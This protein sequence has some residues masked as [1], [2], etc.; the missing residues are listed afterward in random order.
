MRREGYELAVSR[1]E[2]IIKEI[3]GVSCEPYENVVIDIEEQH[4]GD[5][6]QMLAEAKGDMKNMTPD[7][8]LPFETEQGNQFTPTA[9]QPD[10]SSFNANLPKIGPMRNYNVYIN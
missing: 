9:L 1:P 10:P 3:D 7:G 2:V 8:L 5:I 6:M 4:Q